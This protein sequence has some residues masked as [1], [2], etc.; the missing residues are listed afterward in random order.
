MSRITSPPARTGL[1]DRIQALQARLPGRGSAA[2]TG[3]PSAAMFGRIRR[4][5]TL[6][7]LAILAGILI[8][9]GTALYFGVRQALLAPVPGYLHDS[10]NS[11]AMAWQQEP[12]F[13]QAR[14]CPL[15]PG[16]TQ[17]VPYVACY[18]PVGGAAFNV[19]QLPNAFTSTV[20]VNQLLASGQTQASDTV[21]GENGLGPISRYA[22][23]V[24]DA[25]QDGR[26][27][28]I[29]Q[30]GIPLQ[31]ELRS[32]DVLL[33]LLLALGALTLGGAAIGSLFLSSRAL[34]PARLAFTRQQT[35]IAD[36]AHEIR[37]P[38]TLMRADAEVL[39]RGRERLD[40]DDADLLEDIVAET[41]HMAALAGNMLTLA[42][43]DAGA[44]TIER[45]V[46]NLAEVAAAVTRRAEALAKEKGIA[47]ALDTADPV[48]TLGDRAL[49]D[50][51]ALILLDNALKYNRPGGSVTLRVFS[52]GNEAVLEVR[53]TGEGIPP[54]HLPHLGERFYRVD[55]ARS[56]EQGGAGLGLSIARGIAAA[57]G[58]T[59]SFASAP[60]EGT[61][62][63]LALPAA[64]T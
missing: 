50:H 2:L 21:N 36:A 34:A 4:R 22:V 5:L 7:Y 9:A 29:V 43:L 11:I 24:R 61:T 58:G 59:L 20:L 10:A 31:G 42:R 48:L 63:T 33:A 39:L 56:R 28:G 25:D 23:V 17:H 27:I 54:E 51:A 15:P 12:P 3:D 49:L 62:A 8:L 13:D 52:A 45:D 44:Q 55:K 60:G 47:L 18:S 53:D 32:L 37:T 30:V 19:E 57:H 38:L 16:A 1:T 40:P 46:V 6:W 64:A 14:H 35:F 41:A 26:I